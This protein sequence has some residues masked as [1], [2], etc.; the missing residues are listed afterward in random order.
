MDFDKLMSPKSSKQQAQ[1][2]SN[3]KELPKIFIK[4]KRNHLNSYVYLGIFFKVVND[5]D[6]K[7][8]NSLFPKPKNLQSCEKGP[9]FF[10]IFPKSHHKNTFRK[11]FSLLFSLMNS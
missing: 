4:F 7:N 3:T 10:I 11:K 5:T 2:L 8:S 1:I 6:K 9:F